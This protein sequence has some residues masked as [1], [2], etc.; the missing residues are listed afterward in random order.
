MENKNFLSQTNPDSPNYGTMLRTERERR[1]HCPDLHVP[2]GF[3]WDCVLNG[4]SLILF[5][6]LLAVVFS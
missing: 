1:L 6:L 4:G 2:Q 3:T 5:L